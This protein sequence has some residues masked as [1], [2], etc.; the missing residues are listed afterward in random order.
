MLNR[1][2]SILAVVAFAA[3][4]QS[5]LPG[6]GKSPS[7]YTAAWGRPEHSVDG[8]FGTR[9]EV[10]SVSRKEGISSQ[11]F[12]VHVLFRAE[13]SV[14]E[15][16]LRPGSDRWQKDELWSVLD[17]KGAKFELLHQ[18]TELVSPFNVLR[19]PNTLINFMPPDGVM[20]AQLQ[21][22]LQGPQLLI[23]SRE[24]AQAKMDLG[25]KGVQEVGR[26]ASQNVQSRVRPVWGGKS[27]Q[28]LVNGLQDLG[29]KGNTHSYLPRTG[30]GTLAL[31]SHRGTR[32]ELTILDPTIAG[33]PNHILQGSEPSVAP[34][35]AALREDFRHFYGL[36]N[37]AVPGLLG[38]DEWSV[39]RVEGTFTDDVLQD[40]ISLKH[41][42][43]EFTLLSW[44]D[45]SSGET[46]DLVITE[47]GYRLA[48]QWPA[49]TEPR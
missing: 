38:G 37:H 45:A 3:G 12:E 16:W 42:P 19:T 25:L 5:V 33:E 44:Q 49:G 2:L 39:D 36:A 14:E 1:V 28:A 29:T 6:M 32:L 35:R 7:D 20:L 47:D 30:R 13:R 8:P 10:W 31:I 46:W 40:L 22:T 15:R 48:I 21:N 26:L 27:F 23:S 17:G 11:D 34:L 41:L 4:A 9:D 24:W 18:G 43:S